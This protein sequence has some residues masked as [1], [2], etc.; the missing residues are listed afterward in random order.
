MEKGEEKCFHLDFL[1]QNSQNL[2]KHCNS[3][4]RTKARLDVVRLHCDKFANS[5]QQANILHPK[6]PV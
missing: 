6:V 5:P 4:R 3:R 2:K 1:E